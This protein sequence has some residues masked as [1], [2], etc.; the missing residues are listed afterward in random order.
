MHSLW[1][2]INIL[3]WYNK[4]DQSSY[5]LD[6]S[7]LKKSPLEWWADRENKEVTVTITCMI[8]YQRQIRLKCKLLIRKQHN[9]CANTLQIHLIS[10]MGF[11][12]GHFNF[13]LVQKNDLIYN[14]YSFPILDFIILRVETLYSGTIMFIRFKKPSPSTNL[15]GKCTVVVYLSNVWLK[16][17]LWY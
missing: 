9:H 2:T 16:S 8:N 4:F 5:L 3:W 15:N 14:L 7:D 12:A 11:I 10:C 17:T 1:W 6:K 13:V